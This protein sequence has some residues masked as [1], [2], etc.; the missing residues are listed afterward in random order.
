MLCIDNKPLHCD[1]EV[2]TRRSLYI[3]YH[4]SSEEEAYIYQ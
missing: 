2:R 1:L 3:K 4:S